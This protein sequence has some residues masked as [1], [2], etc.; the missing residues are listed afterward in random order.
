MQL[1]HPKVAQPKPRAFGFKF[2]ME[3]WPSGTGARQSVE[4]SVK[5]K[6]SDGKE[7]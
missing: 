7:D 1:T 4:Q 5:D 6:N 3:L 2:A